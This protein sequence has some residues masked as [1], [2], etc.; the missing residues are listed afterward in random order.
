MIYKKN[1][2][3]MSAALIG[4]VLIIHAN[5]PLPPRGNEYFLPL[6]FIGYLLGWIGVFK[7]SLVGRLLSIFFV[8]LGSIFILALLS[9]R[10]MYS[11]I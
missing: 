5:S 7:D 6:F 8:V 9:L 2:F 10:G 1:I 4:L 11:N 3:G